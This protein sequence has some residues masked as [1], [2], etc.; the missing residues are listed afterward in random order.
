MSGGIDDLSALDV[1][2]GSEDHLEA[3]ADHP[4]G[5]DL[6]GH[7]VNQLD[8]ELRHKVAGRGLA[9]EDHGARC[10]PL[11]FRDSNW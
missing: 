5:I 2:I 1:E 10:D 7:G 11:A 6:G 8:N 3:A 4:V 9:A